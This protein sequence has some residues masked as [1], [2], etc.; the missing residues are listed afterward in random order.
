MASLSSCT[1][2]S[3]ITCTWSN[4]V[5][6]CPGCVS[7]LP[8]DLFVSWLCLT[9]KTQKPKTSPSINELESV[10]CQAQVSISHFVS[11]LFFKLPPVIL[12]SSR[13]RDPLVKFSRCIRT[14]TTSNIL[15]GKMTS[16]EKL[17]RKKI[18]RAG[19]LEVISDKLIY[20][21]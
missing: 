20:S 21:T 18:V 12:M 6:P 2:A 14:L 10:G 15:L 7:E 5:H 3:I 4:A 8:R 9:F 17:H 19:K 13:D 11:V 16:F 1:Q